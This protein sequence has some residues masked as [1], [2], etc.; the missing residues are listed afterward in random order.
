MSPLDLVQGQFDAYNA[1]DLE[2]FLSF[3]SDDVR[4]VRP[5]S[6]EA[7][8]EGKEAFG[9]FYRDQRFNKKGLRAEL[10]NRIVMGNK[11]FDHELIH[12]V[13]TEPIEMVAVFEVEDGLIRTVM[14]FSPA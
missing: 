9:A 14:G 12:G 7:V 8:I 13:A 10:V 1:R 2:R 11:I 4:V 5:P 6:G 3:F